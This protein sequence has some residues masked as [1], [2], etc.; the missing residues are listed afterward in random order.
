VKHLESNKLVSDMVG[1]QVEVLRELQG[2]GVLPHL[3]IIRDESS[4]KDPETRSYV[5]SLVEH[6]QTLGGLA[7]IDTGELISVRSVPAHDVV[8]MTKRVNTN[9]NIHGVI[10]MSPMPDF[11]AA[12]GELEP[13]LDIDRM[14]S[15][16][17]EHGWNRDPDTARVITGDV[18]ITAEATQRLLE[19]H[20]RLTE[21]TV[22]TQF[23]RGRT[24]G[25]PL[26]E[27]LESMNVDLR[28]IGR[29]TSEEERRAMLDESAVVIGAV[30]RPVIRASELHDGQTVV[31]VGLDDIYRDVYASGLDIAVTPMSRQEAWGVGRVTSAGAW[32]RTIQNAADLEGIQIALGGYALLSS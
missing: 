14:G 29:S 22:V 19:Y 23:G 5:R 1:Q 13:A 17:S 24:V 31:G 6:A 7:G 28:I 4:K 12:V 26:A 16:W 2:N 3:R 10:H 8:L 20:G 27:S 21:G 11:D 30:G 25:G 32:E 18:P 15:G 9:L